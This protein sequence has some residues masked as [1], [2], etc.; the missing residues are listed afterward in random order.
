MSSYIT[1]RRFITGSVIAGS[2]GLAGCTTDEERVLNFTANA[3]KLDSEQIEESPYSLMGM[4]EVDISRYIDEA[5][6]FDVDATV[7]S[8]AVQYQHEELPQ[9]LFV[10]STP[11]VET[12]GRQINPLISNDL[13]EILDLLSAVLESADLE[14]DFAVEEYQ[15]LTEEE[16]HTNLGT[17][18]LEVYEV[19]VD[20]EEYGDITMQM[21]L[22]TQEH[23]DTIVL[24]T[25][26]I[27][28]EVEELGPSVSEFI[29]SDQELETAK[30]LLST[31]KQFNWM[32]MNNS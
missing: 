32:E 7:S 27:I 8:Y 23:E 28:Y 13:G 14:T 18:I 12:L 15:R 1:R 5:S 22:F 16:F 3:H 2:I 9:P 11:S 30:E 20:S 26:A 25:G 17:T 31:V 21:P 10:F 19:V 24:A 6:G 4:E 29:D